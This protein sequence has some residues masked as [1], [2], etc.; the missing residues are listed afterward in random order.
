MDRNQK[1]THT[2]TSHRGK[3]SRDIKSG[4]TE[5]KKLDPG[6][7]IT[8]GRYKGR[9][10]RDIIRSYPDWVKWAHTHVHWFD[11][12]QEC[13]QLLNS[14]FVAKREAKDKQTSYAVAAAMHDTKYGL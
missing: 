8:F 12:D 5:S 4:S 3:S 1:D 6:F 11:L 10:L 14:A 9:V 7:V 13:I 2:P